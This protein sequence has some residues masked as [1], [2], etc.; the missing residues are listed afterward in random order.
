MR[1]L[2][3]KVIIA[4][5]VLVVGVVISRKLVV[6]LAGADQGGLGLGSLGLLST[7]ISG[8]L[9]LHLL[10]GKG[11]K[12]AGDLLD[13]IT[14]QVSSQLLGELLQKEIVVSLLARGSDERCESVAKCLE[15]S[16]GR[17]LE[18]RKLGQVDSVAGVL[19]VQSDGSARVDSLAALG[20]TDVA[21]VFEEILSVT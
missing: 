13:L 11:S 2:S 21:K 20:Y 1:D 9:V 18:Q 19:G 16:L 4:E 14:R 10:V 17:G 3:H 6:V 15:L 8:L 7:L 12:R 5:R